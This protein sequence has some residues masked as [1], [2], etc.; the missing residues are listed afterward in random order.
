MRLIQMRAF[1]NYFKHAVH[2][3]RSQSSDQL[4][5]LYFHVSSNITNSN[6]CHTFKTLVLIH[7]HLTPAVNTALYDMAQLILVLSLH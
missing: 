1:G 3:D 4:A 6:I 2:H 5:C 7:V